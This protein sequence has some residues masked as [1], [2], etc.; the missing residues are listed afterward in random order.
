MNPGPT[1]IEKLSG[2]VE[3]VTYHNE[4]NG[5]T[6]IKVSSYRD[7][8]RLVTVVVHQA[9]IF[10]GASMEFWGNWSQHPQ[11]GEQF[12]ATQAIEKKPATAA[13]LEKYLGS[14]LIKGVGPVTA[15]RIVKHFQDK[16]LEIF[17]SNIE[18]LMAVP[19]IA[20]RKL[21]DIKT[22]WVEHKSIRDVMIF[23]QGH[24]ISTLFAVKIFKTYGDRAI[25]NVSKNPYTLARDIYGIGFFSADRIALSMGFL[26]NGEPRIEAGIKHV[27][28]SSREEGHCY[29]TIDQ[30]QFQTKELLGINEPEKIEQVL[31]DLLGTHEIKKRALSSSD[32]SVAECFYSKTLYFDE[33]YVATKVLALCSI[34]IASDVKRISDWVARFCETENITLSE[35]QQASVVGIS[36]RAFSILTG[37]PGCGKTTSTKVLVKLLLAMKKK[38]ILGAPTGRAAQRMSEVIGIESKTIHR[39]LEW[40][41]NEGG[42][43][44]GEKDPLV[45]DF[46]IVDETSML[47]V[48]LTASL[49]K[50][51]RDTTQVLFIGDPD[52]LPSVGAGN[53]LFDLLE[54]GVVA[55]FQLTKVFRQAESS[56]IIRF[57]HKIN[58]GEVPQIESPI[59]TPGLFKAKVDCAFLD[60]EEATQE[61]ARF[62]AKVRAVLKQ[63][64]EVHNVTLLQMGEEIKGRV[65]AADGALTLDETYVPVVNKEDLQREAVLQ[66]PEKFFHVQLQDL[67]Q[68]GNP[69]EELKAVLKKVHPWSSLN[70]GMTGL[71]TVLRLYTKTIPE[72]LGKDCEI[73]I[74]SPQVRGSLGT[75]NLN[76]QIQT[77]VNPADT[78]KKQLTLGERIFRVGDRVIQTRNNYDLGVFNGDIGTIESMDLEEMTCRV[79]Y[80]GHKQTFEYKKEN[81]NDLQLA[82]AITIHKSQ[83]S[84][85]QA[86]IIPV[87]TQ[88]FKMLF[89][90]LIYTGLTRGKKLVIFVGSRKAL[91]LAVQTIDQKVRQTGLR[92][93]LRGLN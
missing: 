54:S 57:A 24:G 31:R 20:E 79:F 88:H 53:I 18:A 64:S 63:T 26:T 11:H 77:T 35:E 47:D 45:G 3:R 48:S 60:A 21:A 27:L 41:P 50:A 78:K 38:V 15:S 51:V 14:G 29:L 49:L 16:T 5:W 84:E 65:T 30:I 12:K 68:A 93:L 13:A 32:G 19:G 17:E 89:R 55:K 23:L 9:K 86:V 62:I 85:F 81:L 46:L 39:L 4:Q 58:K 37:G 74:L 91:A 75:L 28:A 72:I 71:D 7:P 44:K 52:Q 59:A 80:L 66:I 6:V 76:Q 34:G 56:S 73:Q 2:I 22:S 1:N 33:A 61:Q 36:G 10:A 90:N 8:G 92:Q 43:K 67:F 70:H 87:A 25:E 42:F 69:V 82:Y 83:G 40:S